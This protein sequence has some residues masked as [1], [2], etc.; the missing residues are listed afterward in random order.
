MFVD[1]A[2]IIIKSGDG[3]NG[4]VSF[5]RDVYVS[6]GGPDGG[7]GGDGGDVVFVV[8][9]N[10]S[11]L[12]D[13]NFQSKYHSGRGADGTSANRSGKDGDDLII[14]VPLGTTIKDAESGL[15]IADL[16]SK[17]AKF[18]AAKG[19]SG[20]WG[21]SHFATATRQAPNF[22]KPGLKGVEREVVLEIKS[23]ADVGLIGLPNAGKSTLLSVISNAKPKIANYQF[24]TLSPNL[25]ISEING[26]KIVVADIPGLI[27]GA[28]SGLGLGHDFL[29]HIERTKILVHV[30]DASE[31]AS[32]PPKEAYDMINNELAEYS[33]ELAKKKQI[34]VLSKADL[35]KDDDIKNEFEGEV[36][37][38]SAATHTGLNELMNKILELVKTT[39]S[40]EFDIYEIDDKVDRFAYTIHKDKIQG[41]LTAFFVEGEYIEGLANMTDFDDP[42][43]AGYF[44]MTL[45]KRGISEELEKMG[46]ADGDIVCVGNKEF[47]YEK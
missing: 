44:Q 23:I 12:M 8:D 7:D 38:I 16:S 2:K 10:L 19:G 4:C 22:A 34:V 18:L 17:D 36:F 37:L 15:A 32:M 33:Q 5:R 11:T 41:G 31:F 29:R 13:F 24:T 20:G 26:E 46:I 3:G 30:I 27:E 45:K 21:N 47:D 35:I 28:H 9:T 39:Q 42:Q 14:K 43:T 40:P 1:K 25:G 6:A